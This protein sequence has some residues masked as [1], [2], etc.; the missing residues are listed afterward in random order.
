M[1][2]VS[3]FSGIGSLEVALHERFPKAKCIGYSEVKKSAIQV[4]ER[5]FPGVPNLGDIT[6]IKELPEVPDLIL[7]GFPCTNLSR[8]ASITDTQS[9]IDGPKSGLFK[10][11]MRIVKRIAKTNPRID[12]I[13]ENNVGMQK[14][15]L[16]EILR[17]LKRCIP[18][19]IY[20]TQLNAAS[21][22]MQH[23]KRY[24]F[25]TF[26]VHP[27][28]IRKNITWKD[29]LDPI[30]TKFQPMSD[31][32][33]LG[34]N[35]LVKS[36]PSNGTTMIAKKK[37]NGT[38]EMIR[39]KSPYHSR[40]A[41]NQWHS[42]K[43]ERSRAITATYRS[44]VLLDYRKG[45]VIRFLTVHELERLFGFPKGYLGNISR[46]KAVDLMGNTIDANCARHV[47]K[48]LER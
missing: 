6:K 47:V 18:K 12:V 22:G 34:H 41:Y 44:L 11:L 9:G 14:E 48:Y 30:G 4:Y 29:V 20:V 8:I 28:T 25:T 39:I 21:F 31:K 19:K 3:F 43:M 35:I 38:W 2:Y 24:F 10:D 33:I 36:K 13:F 45:L 46:H 7:A 17:W 1:K 42:T 32:A 23:R 15:H 5:H 16:R 26:P 27:P 37:K 40:W